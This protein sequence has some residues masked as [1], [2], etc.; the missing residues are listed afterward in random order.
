MPMSAV[1]VGLDVSAE[2]TALCISDAHGNIVME[3]S[4]ASNPEMIAGALRPY[5]RLIARVGLE[6][7]SISAWL[8]KALIKRRY[9]AVCLDAWKT[10]AAMAAQRNKTDRNDARAIAVLLSRGFEA[11]V[12][13]K[14]IEA[15][16]AQTLLLFRNT[17]AQKIH[18]LDRVLGGKLKQFGAKL[19]RGSGRVTIVWAKGQ[20]DADV[21]ANA[22]ALLRMRVA[23]CAELSGLERRIEA[24]AK[25]DPV[26][27]RLMTVPGVGPFIALTFRTAIDDPHR[28]A[29]SRDVAA[30]F[31]LTPR[32]IQSGKSNFRARVSKAGN[33]AVRAALYQAA[34]SLLVCTKRHSTLRAWGL[35]L[36]TK[37]S[38]T[39]ARMACAR[40]LAVVLHRMW[41]KEADFAADGV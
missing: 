22:D 28:F 24:C 2:T 38:L 41:I 18:D 32:R 13:V 29:C 12:H 15:Q 37:R 25:A 10:R 5:R 8:Y 9:P 21:A 17:L 16:R 26:C 4:V 40:K 14:S 33:A 19:R 34:H 1:F 30:Y 11:A 35:R 27:R 23:A 31:G 39:H 7:G 36:V 3:G 6:A 20:R